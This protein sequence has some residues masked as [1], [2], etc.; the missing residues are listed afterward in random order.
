MI[1]FIIPAY[2]SCLTL[3]RA[4]I[5]IENQHLKEFEIIVIDDG[6]TDNTDILLRELEN[7][8]HCLRWRTVSNG[9]V[10]RARNIGIGL[11]KGDFIC[12]LDA[13]DYYVENSLSYLVSI[14]EREPVDCLMFGVKDV[15]LQKDNHT[16]IREVASNIAEGIYTSS[17]EFA[18]NMGKHLLDQMMFSASNKIYR[19]EIIHKNNIFFRE[20]LEIEEDIAFNLSY[21]KFGDSFRII[22]RCPYVY[23]HL[24][25][26]RSLSSKYIANVRQVSLETFKEMT[27]FA[28]ERGGFTGEN[29]RL[30]SLFFIRRTSFW[31]NNFLLKS[32]RPKLK[33]LSQFI[34]EIISEETVQKSLSYA[35]PKSIKDFILIICY[36]FNL[37][38]VLATL[39]LLK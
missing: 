30:M 9:G 21:A 4:I 11:A 37:S 27:R 6:S 38:E 26:N 5:S 19:T 24:S 7:E 39:Y 1:S 32:P 25:N 31:I 12:F 10:S 18:G 20:D 23:T 33:E 15:F 22:N 35:K 29:R 8:G 13:D 14:M 16:V 17:K 36:Q 34:K 2:N 3:E 28:S